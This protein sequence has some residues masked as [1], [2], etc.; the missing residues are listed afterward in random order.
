[1]VDQPPPDQPQP[2]VGPEPGP[3]RQP[4]NLPS[5]LPPWAFSVEGSQPGYPIPPGAYPPGYPIPAGAYPPGWGYWPSGPGYLDPNDPLVTPPGVGISGWLARVGGMV[6]RSWWMVLLIMLVTQ[7]VPAVV[8]GLATLPLRQNVT[9][10]YGAGEPDAAQ[11]E[12][13]FRDFVAFVGVVIVAAVLISLIQSMGWAAGT[14]AVTRQALGEPVRLGAALRYGLRRAPALWGWS[15]LAGVIVAAGFCACVL[16]GIY[17]IFVLSLVGPIVLFER[18]NP[19]GRSFRMFHNRFGMVLGRVAVVA[20]VA[21][22]GN[23]VVV[24]VLG[25]LGMVAVDVD[26]T[27]SVGLSVGIVAMT[28]VAALLN[29]PLYGVYLVGLVV[30]YAEQRAQEAPVTAGQ[31]AAELG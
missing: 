13:L 29:L 31:L 14:W 19:I 11:F 8:L 2:G 18:A 25:S 4:P 16:P 21:A 6:R 9:P 27:G 24:G 26:Q 1:M 22:A 15:L 5:N 12:P 10:V 7:A 28:L 3:D 30:T 23:V 17:F 20:L